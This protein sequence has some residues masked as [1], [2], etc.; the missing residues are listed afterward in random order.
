MANPLKRHD[1]STLLIWAA[2]LITVVRYSAA[3]AVSDAGFIS[4][5]WS[6]IL[7]FFMSLT[8]I[9]M[10]LLDVIGGTYL[11]DGWRRAMPRT[12]QPWPFRFK[13][14]SYFVF[15]LIL[16]GL[17]ILIPFTVSRV[18][19]KEMFDVLGG[20]LWWWSIAVNIAPYLLIGG[21]TL[22]NAGIVSITQD[23]TLPKVSQT[24]E[25]SSD[26]PEGNWRTFSR[27]LTQND[28]VWIINAPDDDIM[29]KYSVISETAKNWK[30]YAV[31]DYARLYGEKNEQ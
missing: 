5:V 30:R 28:L 24:L 15:G 7:T 9:G 29:E 11:F 13:M 17:V 14:L 20:G 8:G 31:R 22:G 25:T 18:S 21:A 12:G 10:G 16:T 23:E 1:Y 3:F 6:E 2:A 19:H 26:K 27:R 4:G